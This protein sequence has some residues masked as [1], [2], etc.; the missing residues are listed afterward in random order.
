MNTHDSGAR[1][2]DNSGRGEKIEC[3]SRLYYSSCLGRFE[4][5]WMSEGELGR[6]ASVELITACEV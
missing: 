5:M 3:K 1:I 4:G 6:A 2:Q